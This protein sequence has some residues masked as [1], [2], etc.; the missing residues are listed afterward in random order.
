MAALASIATLATAGLGI[1][2]QA[3]QAS[4]QAAMQRAQAE[5]AQ[6]AERL[7]QEQLIAQQNAEQ[8]ARA[9]QLART[10]A[11]TR[12]RLAAS[13]VSGGDGSAAALTAGL[14]ADAAAARADDDRIFRARLASGRASLLNPDASFTG[15]VRA[16]Q[17]FGGALR[18]LLD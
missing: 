5:Q 9:A 11:N 4:G 14:Q 8:R 7:R 10:I 12:A 17:A 6:S 18:S 3:R 15:F 13:G 1:Y 16:G 2:G